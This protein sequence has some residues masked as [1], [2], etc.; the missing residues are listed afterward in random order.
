MARK[1]RS[2]SAK[3]SDPIYS[4]GITIALHPAS[5][6]SPTAKPTSKTNEKSMG[7]PLARNTTTASPSTKKRA[8]PA[9]PF[10]T[11]F[12]SDAD[13]LQAL[14]DWQRV[15]DG[16]AYVPGGPI[17]EFGVCVYDE[18]LPIT[19]DPDDTEEERAW[20]IA[21]A[22]ETFEMSTARTARGEPTLEEMARHSFFGLEPERQFFLTEAGFADAQLRWREKTAKAEAKRLRKNALA[23][24]ARSARKNV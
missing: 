6:Q 13:Y 14:E 5:K 8:V 18:P 9:L 7:P 23:R 3:A 16:D 20:R 1:K 17:G 22:K 12:D 2:R 10:R 4:S 21:Y 15:V 24:L 19:H 11:D